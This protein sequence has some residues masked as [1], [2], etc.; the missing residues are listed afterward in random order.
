MMLA[1]AEDFPGYRSRCLGRNDLKLV[2]ETTL[3]R[4]APEMEDSNA[5]AATLVFENVPFLTQLCGWTVEPVS[6][7]TEVHRLC[8]LYSFEEECY[9]SL[10]CPVLTAVLAVIVESYLVP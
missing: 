1:A 10:T 2:P 3:V 8:G 5:A 4:F 9:N 6:S 7:H